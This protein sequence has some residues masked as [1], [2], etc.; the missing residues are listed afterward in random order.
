MKVFSHFYND[1]IDLELEKDEP[2]TNMTELELR[3][4]GKESTKVRITQERG[5]S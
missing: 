5:N 3:P 1:N 2:P 4:R